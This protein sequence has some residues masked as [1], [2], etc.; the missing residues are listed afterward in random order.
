MALPGEV[1]VGA[2]ADEATETDAL[3]LEAAVG[4]AVARAEVLGPDPDPDPAVV[5]GAVPTGPVAE[6]AMADAVSVTADE[7]WATLVAP[8]IGSG[9]G[10]S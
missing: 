10:I 3:E 6:P 8:S 9:P 5:V 1:A 7:A 4:V 2:E